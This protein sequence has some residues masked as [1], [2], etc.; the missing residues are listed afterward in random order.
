MLSVVN[1]SVFF[2]PGACHTL[3]LTQNA[4]A[5]V[6][7]LVDD[8]GKVIKSEH[9]KSLHKTQEEEGLKCGNTLGKSHIE[10]HRH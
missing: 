10:Y 1:H 7:V 3:K 4:L 8:N 6:K 5:D 2:A 9:I